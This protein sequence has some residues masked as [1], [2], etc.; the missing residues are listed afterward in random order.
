MSNEAALLVQE[1]GSTNPS[2]AVVN[3][4]NNSF[5]PKFIGIWIFITANNFLVLTISLISTSAIVYTVA[6]VYINDASHI[7]IDKVMNVV[8]KVMGNRLMPTFLWNFIIQLGYHAVSFVVMNIILVFSF[9]LLLASS[10]VHRII[11]TVIVTISLMFYLMGFTY[12]NV[13]WH[14]A[15]VASILEEDDQLCGIKAMKKSKALIKG[16]LWVSSIICIIIYS[17]LVMIQVCSL[18]IAV[19]TT[20][21]LLSKVMFGI[22]C[23]FVSLLV[24]LVGLVIQSVIYFVCKSYH[25]ENIDKTRL[26]N[27]LKAY[28]VDPV[29]EQ[30]W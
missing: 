12:I 13:I 19:K 5:W 11:L 15:S 26:G 8:P 27:H 7:T 16:K 25:G 10:H 29:E 30:E 9:L 1:K 3:S 18:R 22:L 14:L 2:S 28:Y 4:T 17:F 21:G 24:I 6:C 20:W 23:L